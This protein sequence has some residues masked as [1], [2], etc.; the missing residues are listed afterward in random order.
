FGLLKAEVASS[1]EAAWSLAGASG[2]GGHS[3]AADGSAEETETAMT[4]EQKGEASTGAGGGVGMDAV[5]AAEAACRCRHEAAISRVLADVA[6]LAGGTLALSCGP[7]RSLPADAALATAAEL[8]APLGDAETV[9]DR[10]LA[11]L[12]DEDGAPEHLTSHVVEELCAIVADARERAAGVIAAT[13]VTVEDVDAPAAQGADEQGTRV[14]AAALDTSVSLSAGA[15]SAA[16]WGSPAG[17]RV[18]AACALDAA[19]AG[20]A[21][22]AARILLGFARDSLTVEEVS[23]G[24]TAAAAGTL[25][26]AMR[27][28][29][30]DLVKLQETARNSGS[31]GSSSDGSGGGVSTDVGGESWLSQLQG[32]GAAADAFAAAAVA[33]GTN[34]DVGGVEESEAALLAEKAAALH[35]L[36]RST[37]ALATP[38]LPFALE[39][40]FGPAALLAAFMAPP[41]P[42]LPADLGRNA[43]PGDSEADG[44]GAAATL[45]AAAPCLTKA[46]AVRATLTAA[47][48]AW[49]QLEAAR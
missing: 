1:L 41:P 49:P 25:V 16:L 18:V 19:L 12:R 20:T 21:E 32:L 2:G 28:L 5:A 9:V 48:S 39:A 17:E 8:A 44:S 14:S 7:H 4:A 46:A 3:A 15:S 35:T 33:A 42:Q 10:L 23:Q 45:A 31:G 43:A 11:V 30:D 27:G 6:A 37:S 13:A 26:S 34:N 47:G 22:T 38:P 24:A 36:V 40:D 29:W